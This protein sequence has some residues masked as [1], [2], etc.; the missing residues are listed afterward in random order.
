MLCS[1]AAMFGTEDQCDGQADDD[2]GH[3]NADRGDYPWRY[4]LP[5]LPM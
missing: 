2:A 3:C 4:W 1:A 5:M